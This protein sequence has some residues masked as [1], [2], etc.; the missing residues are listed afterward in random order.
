MSTL[1][2]SSMNWNNQNQTQIICIF[3][4]TLQHNVCHACGSKIVHTGKTQNTMLSGHKHFCW[5]NHV[6]NYILENWLKH[7]SGL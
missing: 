6:W 4:K 1:E 7:V 3:S 5:F 2:K